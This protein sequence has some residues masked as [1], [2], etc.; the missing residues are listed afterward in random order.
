MRM[1]DP[2]GR[3]RRPV[4]VA[5]LVCL[6]FLSAIALGATVPARGASAG[7]HARGP[8]ISTQGLPAA[9]ESGKVL[10]V[11]I[12]RIGIDDLAVDGPGLPNLRMLMEN[13]ATGLMNVRVR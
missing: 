6:A 2:G 10:L 12:D 8:S 11:V 5:I 4:S 7:N 9:N 3:A 13:G 1:T